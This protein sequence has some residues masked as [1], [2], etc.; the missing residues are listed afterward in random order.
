MS[1]EIHALPDFGR[2][3]K[4]LAKKYPSLKKD[5]AALRD[6]LMSNPLTG[7]EIAPGIRK[8]RMA[9]TS[10]GKGKSGGAR[11][12]SYNVILSEIDGDVYLMTIYDKSEHS[13]VDVKLLAETL[14]SLGLL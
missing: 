1:F 5:L 3:V 7:V 12:I 14:K 13:T 4:R 2:E 11:V 6:E 8:I 9:I 10:K